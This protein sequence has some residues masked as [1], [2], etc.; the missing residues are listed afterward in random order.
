MAN[1]QLVNNT[2]TVNEIGE[3]PAQA[4]SRLF[5]CFTHCVGGMS[6]RKSRHAR[7]TYT[8]EHKKCH[9]HKG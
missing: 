4:M 2:V 3:K 8:L 7:R 9:Q 6:T 1:V 5:L